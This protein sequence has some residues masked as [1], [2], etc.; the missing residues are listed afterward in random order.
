MGPLL[1]DP[2]Y[3]RM[4]K[5]LIREIAPDTVLDW[6]EA[7]EYVM[8]QYQS[9]RF[10]NWHSPAP[11]TVISKACCV[12]RT[13]YLRCTNAFRR[14]RPETFR[15]SSTGCLASQSGH[16]AARPGPSQSR[17]KPQSG[18]SAPD[19]WAFQF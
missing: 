15:S 9:M 10:G 16:R 1:E 14:T 3:R 8:S 5:A 12:S 13:D 17:A 7:E 4:R 11:Q 18:R 2:M 6:V 19:R